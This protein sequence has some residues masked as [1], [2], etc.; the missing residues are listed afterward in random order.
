VQIRFGDDVRRVFITTDGIDFAKLAALLR[1]KFQC[2]DDVLSIKY[3]DDEGDLVTITDDD[4][5]K[6]ALL[7]AAEMEGP[8]RLELMGQAA[9]PTVTPKEEEPAP[10]AGGF[11]FGAGC[12]QDVQHS[13]GGG[14]HGRHGRHGHGHGHGRHGH[15]WR[16]RH[17]GHGHGWHAHAHGHKEGKKEGWK[18]ARKAR[19]IADVT[20]YATDRTRFLPR[21]ATATTTD[22]PAARRPDGTVVEAGSKVTKIWKL[23]NHGS[24]DWSEGTQLLHVGG[25]T[26]LETAEPVI[27][28]AAGANAE[29][30][31]AVDLV[32]PEKPGRE[33][34]QPS[35]G[36]CFA[37]DINVSTDLK[38]WLSFQVTSATSGSP[39]RAACASASASG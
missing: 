23:H 38:R 13:F 10:D 39:A 18:E 7:I 29:I 37:C 24:K 30:D 11:D 14:R 32:A 15:G 17:H 8:F 9:E 33:S 1:S 12:G 6:M 34:L 16:G 21:S 25:D 4:E 19:F 26:L 27:V 20:L 28:D 35:F 2:Q 5:L 22:T 36:V 3:V 31:V